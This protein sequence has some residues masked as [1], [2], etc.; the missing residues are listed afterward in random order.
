VLSNTRSGRL[1][2]LLQYVI[3]CGGKIFQHEWF[4]QDFV[5]VLCLVCCQQFFGE[6]AG[7]HDYL[8]LNSTFTK[9]VNQ[10]KTRHQ[11]HIVIGYKDIKKT[12]LE[13]E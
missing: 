5:Y 12:G 2:P 3:E 8:S 1:F 13:S 10:F 7:Y 11:R 6:R 4:L 9:M